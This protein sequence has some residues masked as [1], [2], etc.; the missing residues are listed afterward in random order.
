MDCVFTQLDESRVRCVRCG[1]IVKTP[2]VA[3]PERVKA[4]CRSSKSLGLGDTVA[5]VFKIT[6]I[7][8]LAKVAYRFVGKSCNCD[9]RQDKLNRIVPYR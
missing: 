1:R 6:G 4:P 2:Y 8:T 7:T 3:E 9:N 5:K